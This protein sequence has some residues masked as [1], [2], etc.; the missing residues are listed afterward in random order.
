[1]RG[2]QPQRRAILGSVLLHAVVGIVAWAAG[3]HAR[4]PLPELRT[5]RVHIVSP[6]PQAAGE[7]EPVTVT[8]EPRV[9]TPEPTPTPPPEQPKPP[10]PKPPVRQPT[11]T[12]PAKP[13]EPVRG[14]TPQATSPGGSGLNVRLEGEEFPFPEY[15]QNIITQTHRYFR[16]TGTS[17]LRAEVYFVINRDGSVS[18]IRILRSSGDLGFDLEAMG[19]IEQA[20][21][22]RAYGPLPA[23]F[24]GDRF[25]VSFYFEPA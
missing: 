2:S 11:T 5:Y 12:A 8:P 17:R 15:L 22:R 21:T 1:V 23:G 25:P 16:W 9:V 20:G 3:L 14:R 6:P 19:A 18:D 13:P 7:P 10:P 24:R 4:A